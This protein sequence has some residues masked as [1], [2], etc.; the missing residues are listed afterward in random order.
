MM[1]MVGSCAAF[2]SC[3]NGL[4]YSNA[5]RNYILTPPG[6]E[7]NPPPMWTAA[8]IVFTGALNGAKFDGIQFGSQ[9]MRTTAT[10]AAQRGRLIT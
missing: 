2:S 5:E 4:A 8:Q 10:P 3:V 7:H 9:C 1:G 6:L